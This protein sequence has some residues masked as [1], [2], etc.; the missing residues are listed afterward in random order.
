MLNL[1]SATRCTPEE[2]ART[3]LGRSA[4]RLPSDDSAR[5]FV[6]Y[7]NHEGLPCVY[8]RYLKEE[9]REDLVVFL[10]DDLW[11]DD[12]FFL[13]R[14]REALGS[15]DVAGLAGNQRLVEEAPAW[16]VLNDRMEWDRKHLTG[17]VCHGKTPFG[18]C[19][20]YGPT[21]ALAQLLD[22]VLLAARVSSLLDAGV[23]FDERFDF[24]FYDLDFSR[25]ANRAGLKVGTW[26][27]AVTHSSGGSYNTDGWRR[28]L[29]LYRE[30]WSAPTPG[31][32]VE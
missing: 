16:H 32:A 20:C 26:P 2:F 9:Y 13:I 30:K 25:Q 21:P 28:N 27:I 24:H 19:S 1:V 12:I 4:A 6:A 31:A 18:P 5:L 29:A 15:L 11:I 23:R 14:I 17:A 3:P 22:G 10:H 7:G 8:N